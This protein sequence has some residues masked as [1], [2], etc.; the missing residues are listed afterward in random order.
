MSKIIAGL[1][2]AMLFAIFV[3]AAIA[4]PTTGDNGVAARR[5]AAIREARQ[6]L[7]R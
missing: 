2:M 5:A 3:F 1:V 6:E 4:A 7:S